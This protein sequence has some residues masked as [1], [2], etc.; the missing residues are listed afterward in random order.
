MGFDL[1]AGRMKKI[2][3]LA[4]ISACALAGDPSKE[5]KF[6][7]LPTDESV[8]VSPLAGD[9]IRILPA[10]DPPYSSGLPSVSVRNKIFKQSGLSEAIEN[11]DDF[12]KDSLYLKLSKPGPKPIERIVS[13]H[14]ELE[15][16]SLE[17]AQELILQAEE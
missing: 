9:N 13:K 17:K 7:I 16:G 4:L 1:K 8:D 11:W 3:L 14:P 10:Q 5:D 12:E 2:L 6:L 15:K